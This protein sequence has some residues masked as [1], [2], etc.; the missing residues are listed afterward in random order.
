L[1]TL[2]QLQH[3]G[4]H[5]ESEEELTQLQHNGSHAESDEL[6]EAR[7]A[8]TI[9]KQPFFSSVSPIEPAMLVWFKKKNNK[10][11]NRLRP[12]SKALSKTFFCGVQTGFTTD[13]VE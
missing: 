7:G 8:S 11:T 13:D 10:K 12:L 4:S 6:A 1:P 5:A 9:Q 3:N 2:T